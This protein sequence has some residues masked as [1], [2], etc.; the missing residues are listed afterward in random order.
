M[1]KRRR[2][3][4]GLRAVNDRKTVQRARQRVLQRAL[5]QGTITNKDAR[6]AMGL[7]QVW[8]HL[9]LLAKAGVLKRTAYNTWK[10]TRRGRLLQQV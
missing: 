1:A 9:N 3:S 2:K 8:Y 5:K 10:V 4:N 7:P 6:Q